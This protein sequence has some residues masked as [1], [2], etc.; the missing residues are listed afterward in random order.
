[1]ETPE[2][3]PAL[4][5]ILSVAILAAAYYP[6]LAPVYDSHLQFRYGDFTTIFGEGSGL[7]RAETTFFVFSGGHVNTYEN[8]LFTLAMF[9][10]LSEF[11]PFSDSQF[12]ASLILLSMMLGCVGVFALAKR[13]EKRPAFCAAMVLFVT[14]F[15]FLNFWAV[16]R[17]AHTWIW[18]TYAVFP[19]FLF[20]GLLAVDGGRKS[21]VLYS[22]VFGFFGFLP[23]SF[24]YLGMIHGVLVVY[25]LLLGRGWKESALFAALPLVIYA[26]INLPSLALFPYIGD[27]YPA[28]LEKVPPTKLSENGELI[29]VFAFSNVWWPQIPEWLILR[30]AAFRYSGIL[31][32]ALSFFLLSICLGRMD[33]GKR[34]LASL[35]V[36]AVLFFIFMAQ[37]TNNRILGGVIGWVMENGLTQIIALFREWGRISIMIPLFL[38]VV[39]LSC[40]SALEGRQAGAAACALL[41]LLS[42]NIVRSPSNAYLQELFAAKYQHEDNAALVREIGRD[43]K[44]LILEGTPTVQNFFRF[45]TYST[46]NGVGNVSEKVELTG[47]MLDAY[48]FGYVIKGKGSEGIGQKAYE[49][50]DCTRLVTVSLCFN[51]EG[52]GYIRAYSGSIASDNPAA[53]AD[54]VMLESGGRFAT[55]LDSFGIVRSIGGNGSQPLAYILEGER[56]LRGGLEEA[57]FA[58]GT[59]MSSGYALLVPANVSLFSRISLP[60]SGSFM[61]AFRGNGTLRIKYG[62]QSAL[63]SGESGFFGPIRMEKGNAKVEFFTEEPSAIDSIWLYEADENAGPGALFPSGAAPRIISEEKVSPAHW[64][65][66]VEAD[67]PF[68]LSLAEPYNRWFEARVK[69]EDGTVTRIKP[70]EV[71]GGLSG[72]AVNRTGRLSVDI[73]YVPQEPYSAA[74]ASTAITVIGCMAFLAFW[75]GK[76]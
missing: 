2:K 5:L 10:A 3:L 49:W 68:L 31:I 75:R 19:L 4:A 59:N 72:F 53:H 12:H 58:Y 51:R 25:A 28:S 13:L 15:Y 9:S 39:L 48:G 71:Q 23:H 74:F 14:L 63:V 16:D 69:G 73:I 6:V 22:L 35:S 64:K 50:L 33:K 62:N 54:A 45:T 37:G 46:F 7:L 38:S 44:V 29:N 76:R 34:L 21:L 55:A 56:D 52:A 1:M 60:R 18:F 27:S 70:V 17:L 40:V 57:G 32:F 47:R 61:G 8:R 66:E 43:Y 42:V 67:A 26:G 20:L 24:M 41:I 65:A 11:F 30:N 36:L